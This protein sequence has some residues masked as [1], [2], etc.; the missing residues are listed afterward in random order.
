[1]EVVRLLLQHSGEVG[2]KSRSI[3]GE[4]PLFVAINYPNVE[5]EN[6]E[7]LDLLLSSG[8]DVNMAKENQYTPLMC[9]S[10]PEVA[11]LFISRGADVNYASEETGETPLTSACERDVNPA[12]VELLLSRGANVNHV[13]PDGNTP[14][15]IRVAVLEAE[16]AEAAEAALQPPVKKCETCGKVRISGHSLQTLCL[17]CHAVHYCDRACQKA[18]WPRHKNQCRNT[19]IQDDDG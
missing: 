9:T 7:I 17:G 18:D 3:D 2:I 6:H 13:G 5:G 8:A 4:S 11:E 16:A 1:M 14:W 10:D 15:M 12:V 19:T